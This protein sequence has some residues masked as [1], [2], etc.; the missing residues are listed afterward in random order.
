[1]SNNSL[2]TPHSSGGSQYIKH[3]ARRWWWC[4]GHDRRMER[5]RCLAM[6]QRRRSRDRRSNKT[7]PHIDSSSA[8]CDVLLSLS[9]YC[10]RSCRES[11]LKAQ[12]CHTHHMNARTTFSSYTRFECGVDGWLY[13][14]Y[15]IVGACGVKTCDGIASSHWL[16]ARAMMVLGSICDGALGGIYNTMGSRGIWD[17]YC[18]RFIVG[19]ARDE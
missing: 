3:I 7:K 5:L 13:F 10:Y 1:M 9:K 2:V 4:V 16:T 11:R 14:G 15:I 18:S 12:V 8:L 17:V 6:R 19:A